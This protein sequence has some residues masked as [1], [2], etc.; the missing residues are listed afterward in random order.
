MEVSPGKGKTETPGR[1]MLPTWMYDAFTR[2][3]GPIMNS[4]VKT[5][6]FWL[7]I[8]VSA[9]L[10]WEIVKN[11]WYGQ[12]DQEM[13]VTQLMSDV[14]QNNIVGIEVYGMEVHG[15]HRDGTLFHTTAPTNYFTPELLKSLHDK[16]VLIR[17]RDINS[18]SIPL[19][20]LGT[21]AP[22][23]LLGALWT[24]MIRQMQSGN[25]VLSFDKVRAARLFS[26]RQQFKHEVSF[27]QFMSDIEQNNIQEMEVADAGHTALLEVG[28]RHRDAT[29]FHTTAPTNLFTPEL[30][31]SLYD[32]GI[33]IKF[34]R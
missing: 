32:K 22:L 33:L 1:L 26:M 7:L 12:E 24:F 10:L 20:L 29:L 9:L 13:I 23:I 14:E 28:G 19:T 5:V 31:K 15:R 3:A 25:K 11:A 4:T 8:G 2:A 30:L 6:L 21:W 27:T 17:F 34:R 18:G 16:G